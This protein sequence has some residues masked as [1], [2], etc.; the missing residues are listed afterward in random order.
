MIVHL[1]RKSGEKKHRVVY[2]VFDHRNHFATAKLT[3]EIDFFARIRS[4][5]RKGTECNCFNDQYRIG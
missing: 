2:F 5:E 4:G 3:V 1:D